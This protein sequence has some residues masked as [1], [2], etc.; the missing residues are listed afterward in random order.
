ML[1]PGVYSVTAIPFG[2]AKTKS[3]TVVVGSDQTGVDFWGGTYTGDETPPLV[4]RFE[5]LSS[6]ATGFSVRHWAYDPETGIDRMSFRIGTT[7][8]A[9][10]VLADT[11]VLPE[12]N[13][14][15]FTGLSIPTFNTFQARYVNGGGQTTTVTR[16]VTPLSQDAYVQNGAN[17]AS[18]FGTATALHVSTGGVGY[19]RTGYLKIDTSAIPG[20]VSKVTLRFAATKWQATSGPVTVRFMPTSSAWTE[21]TVTSN[22]APASGWPEVAIAAVNTALNEYKWYEIDVTA[23]VRAQR[24]LGHPVVSLVAQMVTPSGGLDI[25]SREWTRLAPQVVVTAQN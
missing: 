16:A 14:A 18:N 1:P 7:P 9:T 22:N 17:A 24:A 5:W 4:G 23:Y 13:T 15:A 10:N 20:D 12:S 3:A 11:E 6:S 21:G 25:A 2:A 8:G 19:L